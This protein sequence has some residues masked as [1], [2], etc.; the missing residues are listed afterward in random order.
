MFSFDLKRGYH[1]IEISEQHQTF[2]GFSWR[3]PDFKGEVFYVVY[4]PSL[5]AFHSSL[6]FHEAAETP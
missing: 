1:H 4:G 3:S 6:Y 2:L 5:W